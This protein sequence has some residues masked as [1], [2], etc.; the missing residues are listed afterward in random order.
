M[1]D[2]AKVG[3]TTVTRFET[4]QTI[5]VR[6]TLTVIQQAFEEA[7]VHFTA[8]GGVIPPAQKS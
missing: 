6:S 4:G 5:P 8:E 3:V 1:A 2:K 7:G